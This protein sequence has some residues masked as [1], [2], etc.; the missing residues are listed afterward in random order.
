MLYF[1]LFWVLYKLV[2]Q[3]DWL[4]NRRKECAAAGDD[5][6]FLIG[7]CNPCVRDVLCIVP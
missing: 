1:V 5:Q 7:N 2:F 3:I 4:D 6:A